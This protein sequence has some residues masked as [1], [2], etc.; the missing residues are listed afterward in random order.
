MAEVD[1]KTRVQ[2]VIKTKVKPDA[3]AA[4]SGA[5]KAVPEL[6]KSIAKVN[7][8]AKQ[9]V[10]A[11]LL[12]TYIRELTVRTRAVADA[13]SY[14]TDALKTLKEVTSDDADFAADMD[15]IEK[16]QAK[17]ESV[18][19]KLGDQLVLAK[20]ASDNA[21]KA[22]DKGEKSEKTARREW[23]GII[24]DFEASNAVAAAY[25]KRMR[26]TLQEA[27]DA[28]KERDAATLKQKKEHLGKLH[29]N[30]DVAEGKLLLKRT[31]ELLAHYDIPQF[32][33]EFQAQ[34]AQD[35]VKVV[36]A[37]DK[38]SKDVQIEAEK[39]VA[40]MGKLEITPPDAVKSTAKL[41]FKANFIARV[42]KALKLDEGK[43]M[44]ELEAIGKD[45]GV[46]GSGKELLDKLKKEKLYP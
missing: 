32:S 22:A 27:T 34:I 33:K 24:A 37:Y 28:A 16:L 26:T 30:P 38:R 10:D 19:D 39:I 3:D 2:Q 40:D 6:T 29:H 9:G 15:E 18:R 44:K 21:E 43:L 11:D 41:G 20:Q 31:S 25:V 14:A 4:F 36:A 12:K 8:A 42:E 1:T 45:A 17:L 7:Q 23:A 13:R 5:V 35:K 46:K